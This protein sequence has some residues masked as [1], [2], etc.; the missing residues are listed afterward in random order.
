[1]ALKRVSLLNMMELREMDPN[2]WNSGEG[3]RA[4][5]NNQKNYPETGLVY[6][7]SLGNKSKPEGI[8]YNFQI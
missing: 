6:Y 7:Y 4:Q 2:H 8:K 1:M 5:K 3:W